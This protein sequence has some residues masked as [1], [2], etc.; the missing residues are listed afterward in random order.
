MVH[1]VCFFHGIGEHVAHRDHALVGGVL[2][3]LRLEILGLLLSQRELLLTI[4]QLSCKC[5]GESSCASATS[6]ES[7]TAVRES[8]IYSGSYAVP[9]ALFFRLAESA[10]PAAHGL[11]TE[12]R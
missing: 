7:A 6:G 9:R 5:S 4:G 11:G 10:T 12:Q 1:N 3:R 2:L 8:R